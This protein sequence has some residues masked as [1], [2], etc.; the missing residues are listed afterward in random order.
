MKGRLRVEVKL[1]SNQ[2]VE[3]D[4]V[5][6]LLYSSFWRLTRIVEE[7]IRNPKKVQ[8]AREPTI[9]HTIGIILKIIPAMERTITTNDVRLMREIA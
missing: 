9:Q 4:G 7:I 2:C 5:F 3:G 8:K 6:F 1:L